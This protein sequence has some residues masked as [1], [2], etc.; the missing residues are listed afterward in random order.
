MVGS[1]WLGIS[2]TAGHWKSRAAA[3]SVRRMLQHCFTSCLAGDVGDGLSQADHI[4]AGRG[5]K[6]ACCRLTNAV[7]NERR[8]LGLSD[9]AQAGQASQGAKDSGGTVGRVVSQIAHYAS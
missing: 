8:Q 1:Q 5:N 9:A 4:H 6:P 3:Q 7:P 2:T